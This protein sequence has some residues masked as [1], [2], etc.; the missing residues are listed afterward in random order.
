MSK[1]QKRFITRALFYLLLL[2]IFVYITFP[3]YWS[4]RSSVPLEARP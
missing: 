1:T 4:I 2:V 3:F